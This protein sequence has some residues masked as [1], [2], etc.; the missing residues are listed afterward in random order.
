MKK[1]SQVRFFNYFK[2]V[3]GGPYLKWFLLAL[4]FHFVLGLDLC[5]APW[6]RPPA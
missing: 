5:D 2:V 6:L 1:V 3:K 4:T